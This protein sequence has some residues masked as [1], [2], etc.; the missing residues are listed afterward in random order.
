MWRC[1]PQCAGVSAFSPPSPQAC[2]PQPSTSAS[3]DGGKGTYHGHHKF[4][5]DPNEPAIQQA[6][7]VFDAIEAQE[8]AKDAGK[9]AG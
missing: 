3:S 8:K 4:S 9:G 6:L 1:G 5:W 7:A 2:P